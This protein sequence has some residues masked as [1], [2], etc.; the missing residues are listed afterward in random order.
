MILT[1]KKVIL[2]YPELKDAK[3]L[4]VNITKP[5]IAKN[6]GPLVLKLKSVK[7]EIAWI[8]K[9]PLMRKKKKTLNFA[10]VDKK[11]KNLMGACGI[12]EFH[13]DEKCAVLGWWI[14]KKYW[15]QA[16]AYDAVKALINYAF[17][18]YKLNRLEGYIYAYNPRS[19]GFA[20]KLGFK[21]EGT[22]RKRHL[23]KGKF[24]DEWTIGLLHTE[25]K[26]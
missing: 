6:L 16:Y 26:G 13:T 9:Q 21:L 5:E 3:W 12:N 24:Y 2:R 11:T 25:W 10:I 23:Y 15:G 19:L 17:K 7:Q 22:W 14:A 8:K 18:K 20:K 1:G 4:F